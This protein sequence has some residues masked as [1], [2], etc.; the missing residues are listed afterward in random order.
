VT[1][2]PDGSFLIQFLRSDGVIVEIS[3][4]AWS[5]MQG[6]IQFTPGAREAGG[7]MLG[8][9]LRDCS[10]III[11]AVTTPQLGD[12]RSRARFHRARLQHQALIDQ[13]WRESRGTCTYL[14]EWHTHPEP[15]LTP[16]HI[17]WADWR[18]RLREDQYTEP[19][20]FV[21]LGTAEIAAWTGWRDGRIEQLCRRAP[22]GSFQKVAKA[23]G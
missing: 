21:I 1:S 2:H 23:P 18:R 4:A 22:P 9:H 13:A 11:G 12:R 3:H 17:D 16:S 14:G 6:F 19:I 5:V 8:Y 20:C 7:V 15:I 10:A